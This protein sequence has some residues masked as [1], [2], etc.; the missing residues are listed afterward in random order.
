MSLSGGW[1]WIEIFGDP[2][3]CKVRA[4]FQVATLDGFEQG[5]D[6]GA[7]K[8]LVHKVNAISFGL[9]CM[10]EEGDLHGEVGMGIGKH[11]G[12]QRYCILEMGG[13]AT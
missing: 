4:T 13:H 5:R 2:F 1:A 12:R 9:H 11:R 10:R 3:C 7:A 6:L 8:G